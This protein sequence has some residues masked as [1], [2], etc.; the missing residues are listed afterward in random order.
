MRRLLLALG[1]A[2]GLCAPAVAQVP[3][4]AVGGAAG[5]FPISGI[6]CN[7]EPLI[8]TFGAVG[9]GIVPAASA[10]DVAC[11]TGAANTV[12]RVQRVRLAGSA[13]TAVLLPVALEYRTVADSGGTPAT[14]TA[15]PVPYAIDGGAASTPKATTIAYTANPTVNDGTNR[16]IAVGNLILTLT[17]TATGAYSGLLFDWSGL[18]TMEPPTLRSAAQQVCANF[19]GVSVSSGLV[20]VEFEWTEAAQ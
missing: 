9:Y 6:A 14:T 13:G 5:P 19:L 4:T 7:Q 16:P 20:A 18:R 15:L 1:L 2:L 11:I 3:C 12:I 10:T 17:G 8:N